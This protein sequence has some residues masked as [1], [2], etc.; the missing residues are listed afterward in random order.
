MRQAVSLGIVAVLCAVATV[1]GYAGT[2]V[3]FDSTQLATLV[4]SDVTSDTLSSN[5]YLFTCTRDNLFTGGTGT[6]IGRSL[7]V[8]WPVGVEAQAVTTPPAGSTDYK[9]RLT[10]RRVDGKPFGIVDF[11]VKILANTGGAGATL[12]IMPQ[13]NGEDGFNDPLYF[14][15]TGYYGQT[16]SYDRTPNYWG[17]TA[18]CVGFDTYK[19]SLYVDFAF[20]ALTL[21]SDAVPSDFNGD[22]AVDITDA[23]ALG[24]CLLGPDIPAVGGCAAKDLDYDFDVDLA[25]FADLQC[26]YAGTGAAVSAECG[27]R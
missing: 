23:N 3:F 8:D 15:A 6:P 13:L 5:G 19:A 25:D 27:L 17:T 1:P 12:E 26:C 4:S 11:T 14:D 21:E 16:F 2:T 7:V 10:I 22:G 18:Q 24:Q 9:A 20:I